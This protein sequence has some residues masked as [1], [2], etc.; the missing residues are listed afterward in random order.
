LLFSGVVLF[1]VERY[2]RPAVDWGDEE[3]SCFGGGGGTKTLALL[4]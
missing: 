1:Y 2:D 3:T 4:M